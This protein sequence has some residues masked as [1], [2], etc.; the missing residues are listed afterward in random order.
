MDESSRGR[1]QGGHCWDML[2]QA[3]VF[4]GDAFCH[5]VQTAE[6]LKKDN[7]CRGTGEREWVLVCVSGVSPGPLA[8]VGRG[9]GS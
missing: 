7:A 2:S 3:C 9:E 1:Q 6:T 8:R 5:P 4:A